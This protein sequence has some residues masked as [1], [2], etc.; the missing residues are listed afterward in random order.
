MGF[1]SN[2]ALGGAGGI[3]TNPATNGGSGEGR[4]GAIFVDP[5]ARA[6]A[7]GLNFVD[8]DASSASGSGYTPGVPVDTDDVWGRIDDPLLNAGFESG[9]TSEWSSTVP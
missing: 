6:S 1:A 5:A 3:N 9:T 7:V 2:V 8:N 4:G